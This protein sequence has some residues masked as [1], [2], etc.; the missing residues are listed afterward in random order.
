M[1]NVICIAN[2]E[3]SKMCRTVDYDAQINSIAILCVESNESNF[4]AY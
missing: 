4:E 3:S 1:K 2:A